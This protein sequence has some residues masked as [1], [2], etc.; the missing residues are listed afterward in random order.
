VGQSTSSP[1]DPPSL[2]EP[3]L[4]LPFGLLLGVLAWDLW[5]F[6]RSA[7]E[8][9]RAPYSRDYGEG[10]VLAM[11]QLLAEKGT[12]FSSLEDYPLVH[13]NYPPVFPLLNLP[14][15]LLFGPTLLVP[16]LLSVLATLGLVVVLALLVRRETGG[17][18]LAASF[19]LLLL[20]P[21]FVQTWAALGRV[22]MLAC[23]FSLAGL[24]LF[25]RVGPEARGRFAAYAC[26]ALAFFTKQNALLAPTALVLGLALDPA[27]R[28]RAGRVFVEIA[29]PMLVLFGALCALTGGQAYKH[30]V[31]YTAAADYEW[32]RMWR[33]Y[34]DFLALV[35]PL[36][37]LILP[38]LVALRRNA[39][40]G[41]TAS[42]LFYWLFNLAGLVTISKAGAAQNYFIEPYVATL[43]L[44]ALL[45][46]HG[47]R[48]SPALARAW[49]AYVLVAAAVATFADMERGRA[50]L[51]PHEPREFAELY[52][53]VRATSGPILSED[54]SALVL[55]RKP[56]LVEPFGALLI[57]RKGFLNTDRI[58]SDCRAGRFSLV[59]SDF[60]LREIAGIDACLSERYEPW[61][62][63]GPYELLR[64]GAAAGAP[65]AGAHD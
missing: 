46:G 49:P 44:A 23:L 58:V 47:I 19:A 12:Y 14:A 62:R 13:G 34:R 48:T 26:F 25:H 60:R 17:G 29:L 3:A 1:P 6:G 32:D 20:A 35:G 59:I 65:G 45:V 57:S 27:T 42:Y 64:P 55:N 2:R 39:A 10:C 21:W 11:V 38:A 50:R 31:P 37:A 4:A 43:A 5:R 54:L 52:E 61:K 16:R 18:R 40:S 56:V 15:Y 28:R 22:D 36:V 7:I 63:L 51:P 9:V 24:H 33:A 53:A 8:T 41:P 30:L